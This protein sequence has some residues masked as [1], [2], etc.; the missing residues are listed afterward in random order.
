MFNEKRRKK[1][2]KYIKMC[3]NSIFLF[4]YTSGQNEETLKHCV[5]VHMIRV[6]N[7]D[8]AN[9]VVDILTIDCFDFRD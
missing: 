6:E 4:I 5:C 3:H 9:D 2:R 1:K 7:V 8:G